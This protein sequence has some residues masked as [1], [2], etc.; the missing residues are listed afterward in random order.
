GIPARRL[1]G[2]STPCWLREE[3]FYPVHLPALP[4]RT[5]R[6]GGGR[7]GSRL[8][9]NAPERGGS[10]LLRAQRPTPRQ[11]GLA[12]PMRSEAAMPHPLEAARQDRQQEAAEEFYGVEGPRAQPVATLIVL[13]AKAHLAVFEGEQPL[14]GDRH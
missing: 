1:H 14:V 8:S 9:V 5:Y 10:G 13:V 6:T 2:L 12:D 11:L 4:G 3:C 7:C